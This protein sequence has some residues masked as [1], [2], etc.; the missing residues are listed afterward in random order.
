MNKILRYP[1]RHRHHNRNTANDTKERVPSI[2]EGTPMRF[3][4][5]YRYSENTSFRVVFISSRLAFQ[6]SRGY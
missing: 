5:L 3:R 1:H 2:F 6:A 4:I